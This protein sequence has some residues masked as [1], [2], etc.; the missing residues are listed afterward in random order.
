MNPKYLVAVALL[1]LAGCPPST[2]IP[3]V[4]ATIPVVG[5]V[6]FG[7]DGGVEPG[8]HVVNFDFPIGEHCGILNVGLLEEAVHT[9]VGADAEG[10]LTINSVL[11]KSFVVSVRKGDFLGFNQIDLFVQFGDGAE[12]LF[13]SITADEGL[14]MGF[15]INATQDYELTQLLAAN[16]CITLRMVFTGTTP[17]VNLDMRIDAFVTINSSLAV[18]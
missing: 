11:L 13:G 7:P 1:L 15:A 18:N 12:F 16:D 14:G 10:P 8:Q 2:E 4:N 9:A 17:S 5:I 6:R 3:P